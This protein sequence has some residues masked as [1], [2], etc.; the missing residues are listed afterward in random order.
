[1]VVAVNKMDL[2]DYREEVFNEIV[3]DFEEFARKLDVK[4]V[5]FIPISALKGDN[6]V[7]NSNRMDWYKGTTLLHHLES[8]KVDAADNVTDFRFPCN[9]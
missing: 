7:D 6:V 2:V 3:N 1:M 5:T 8:V 4:D 9:M